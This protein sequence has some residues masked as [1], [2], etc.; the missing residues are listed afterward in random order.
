MIKRTVEISR[1]PA[2]LCVRLNQLTLK[3]GEE[4]VGSIPCEDIGVVVVDH[5]Q[6][7]YT[8]AALASL[9]QAD[10]TLVVCGRDHLPVAMLLPLADHTQVVWRVREQIQA[11]KPLCKRLWR[12]IVQ[13]KIR[14]QAANLAPGSVS[15]RRLLQLASEVR[16][17][18]AT[19]REAQAAKIYWS[20]WLTEAPEDNRADLATFRRDPDGAGANALLNYGYAVTRAAVARALVAAGLLP[21]LGL[22]HSHRAN[23]FCLADDLLEPLRALVDERVRQLLMAG[24][25]D[26]DQPTKAAL[27]ELLAVPM[28]TDE[29][30]GPLLVALHRYVASLVQCFQGA[31]RRLEIPRPCESADTGA[32]GS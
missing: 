6:A 5:P 15:R 9:A 1:E 2:H 20:A 13:A 27:L 30:H 12:Q 18:D 31:A 7:T 29:G 23:A 16:S 21:S 26:L 11:G 17:G 10:A 28:E 32:C 8:H 22:H 14:A 19:N 25:N 4:T 3:R 24:Q